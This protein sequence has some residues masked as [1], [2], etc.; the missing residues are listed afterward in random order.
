MEK[1]TTAIPLKN[2]AAA[3]TAPAQENSN[4]LTKKALSLEA[5]IFLG[6][7]ALIFGTIGSK[8]GA[9]NMVNT[10]MNTAYDLLINTVLYIMAIAVLAGA[11]SGLLMEFGVVAAIN[12]ILS[13]LMKPLY[14]LPAWSAWS[15]PISPIILPS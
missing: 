11:V 13:P 2:K 12:R 10:L 15:R 14:G 7:L 6:I 1:V 4:P 3:A 5:L 9:V 8:M